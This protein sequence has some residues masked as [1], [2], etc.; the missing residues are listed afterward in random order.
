VKTLG[1]L[2]VFL[3]CIF[4]ML[5]QF[6]IVREEFHFAGKDKIFSDTLNQVNVLNP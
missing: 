5:S 1:Y 4:A 2:L 6:A 3:F